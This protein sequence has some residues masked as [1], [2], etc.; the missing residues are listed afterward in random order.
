MKNEVPD[1][2]QG[3]IEKIKEQLK[4]F[5]QI[6]GVPV[7]L[8]SHFYKRDPHLWV[9]GST[10]GRRYAD[11]PRF[12]YEYL[13]RM[14][15]EERKAVGLKPG[16]TVRAVWITHNPKLAAVL[17]K[18]GYE[19]YYYLSDEGRECCKR[20]GVYLFDNYSKD[21]SFYLSGGAKK[22][23]LWHGTPLKKIQMDNRFDRVR[24]P[25]NVW[26]RLYWTLRRMSDEKPSHYVLTTSKFFAPIF[27]S[28]FNTGHVLVCGYPRNDSL[29]GTVKSNLLPGEKKKLWWLQ[30]QIR[31]M[32]QQKEH[33]VE[34]GMQD[35][36]GCRGNACRLARVLCYM[37][38][39]R[40]SE[41][42]FFEKTD[43][44]ELT[45]Y[46]ERSGSILV[47]KLHPKSKLQKEFKER[48]CHLEERKKEIVKER[49]LL[50]EP[51]DDAYEF[52][53]Y[54]D[55]LITDY[56]SV[57]FDYLLFD[58]PILFFNYDYEEYLSQSRELYFHYDE[59]T[60]G[61]KVQSGSQLIAALEAMK[62]EKG[63]SAIGDCDSEES[64]REKRQKKQM[65]NRN[66]YRVSDGYEA[67]RSRIRAYAHDFTDGQSCRRLVK[68]II[69]ETER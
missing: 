68:Q 51:D 13:S 60:P 49:L 27:S 24:N 22:I 1:K 66:Q 53:K 34:E 28:A 23:N 15:D 19:A 50:L 43:L 26:M 33:D 45:D 11:N 9:L 12:F 5:S 4:Y 16:E 38:T 17:K 30:R 21:I 2:G 39:F 57:Y 14:D 48:L 61:K 62:W 7:Y 69:I 32:G 54:S 6:F 47:V 67:H 42:L 56:S 18:Q 58:R 3:M 35:G 59:F 10:F 46:L 44:G 40:E 37:P 64:D 29:L 65:R 55:C 8:A 52:L 25:E 63:N 36:T 31:K 20:A 41:T